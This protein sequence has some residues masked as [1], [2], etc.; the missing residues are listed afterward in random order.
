MGL[1][2]FEVLPHTVQYF[3][4]SNCDVSLSLFISSGFS[5]FFSFHQG[6]KYLHTTIMYYL[7]W[8]VVTFHFHFSFC[9]EL[10]YLLMARF[11]LTFLAHSLYSEV[12]VHPYSWA[13]ILWNCI[14]S[15]KILYCCVIVKSCQ[16][17]GRYW[18][19]S[20]KV[21][22]SLVKKREYLLLLGIVTLSW[23]VGCWKTGER[24]EA[25]LGAGGREGGPREGLACALFKVDKH[26]DSV[27]SGTPVP[28]G[29]DRL[30]GHTWDLK[31]FSVGK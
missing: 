27:G 10:N 21:N 8:A 7:E 30:V 9:H 17:K 4:V 28:S 25:P 19:N 16:K 13:N 12:E 15:H 24:G 18:I 31:L 20:V 3:R 23:G 14:L 6:L 29:P 22:L 5:L 2:G 11:T 1:S 26:W